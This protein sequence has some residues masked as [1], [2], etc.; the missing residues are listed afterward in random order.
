MRPA[1]RDD[2][3]SNISLELN[4]SG[5]MWIRL[6]VNRSLVGRPDQ[7]FVPDGNYSFTKSCHVGGIASLLR[8]LT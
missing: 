3:V 2:S 1:R 8:M 4:T 7:N 5:P 6:G